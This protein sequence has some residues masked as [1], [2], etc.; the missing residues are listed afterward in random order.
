[1]R[2]ECE[3]F[4]DFAVV[5]RSKEVENF[6]LVP[7]AIDRAAAARLADR[8]RRTGE[9]QVYEPAAEKLLA[10]FAE[11]QR[12]YITSQYLTLR[13]RFERDIGSKMYQETAHEKELASFEQKWSTLEGR[14]KLIP[15]KDALSFVNAELQTRYKINVTNTAIIDAMHVSEVPDEVRELVQR[16]D[17][18]AA[19]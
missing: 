4:C 19:T 14:L 3:E 11:S 2:K 9:A 10:E 7:A 8:S 5:H 13:S 15:G 16:L 6:L 1:V 17:V 18:F 12:H